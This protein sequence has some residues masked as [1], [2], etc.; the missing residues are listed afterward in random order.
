MNIT[1]INGLPVDE[2]NERQKEWETK[3][4]IRLPVEQFDMRKLVNQML[5]QHWMHE[6][7]IQTS[8]QQSARFE[9]LDFSVPYPERIK[10]THVYYPYLDRDGKEARW[11]LRYS[12]GP[13]TGTLW[14]SVA[15][16]FHSPELALVELAKAYPPP[17]LGVIPTHGR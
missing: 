17:A 12:N 8:D 2:W 6:C 5:G 1:T 7:V 3:M 16:D 14:D 10:G 11:C 4:A 13:G 15:D 9:D